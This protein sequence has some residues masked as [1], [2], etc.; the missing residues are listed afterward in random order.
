[1]LKEIVMYPWDVHV[2]G[3]YEYGYNGFEREVDIDVRV[4]AR[5]K[6]EAK[7]LAMEEA[8]KQNA[9]FIFSRMKVKRK[10]IVKVV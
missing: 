8:C 6:K 2:T 3:Y 10:D 9:T 5:N 1:M 7:K 4:I